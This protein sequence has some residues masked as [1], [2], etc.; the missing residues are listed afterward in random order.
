MNKD[1]LAALTDEQREDCHSALTHPHCKWTADAV[2]A[3]YAALADARLELQQAKDSRDGFA[4]DLDHAE[5]E[6][7]AMREEGCA[8]IGTLENVFNGLTSPDAIENGVNRELAQ[9]MASAAATTLAGAERCG[10]A[11][12]VARL[13]EERDRYHGLRDEVVERGQILWWEAVV[14]SNQSAEWRTDYWQARARLQ[15]YGLTIEDLERK[16]DQ[17]REDIQ[18]LL[19]VVE[20]V[21]AKA[22]LTG[23]K[24]EDGYTYQVG[25]D[26]DA[27]LRAL[28]GIRD[29]FAAK[30]PKGDE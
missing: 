16:L 12:E 3:I 2:A 6:V 27:A 13:T 9:K 8:A 29:E 25:R 26:G 19:E 23:R 21:C 7:A 30:Y 28:A 18:R 10:H 5:S 11:A 22:C 20:A 4:C 1:Q 17:Q 24:G 14:V 15:N